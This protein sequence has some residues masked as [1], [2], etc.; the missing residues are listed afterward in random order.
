[1]PEVT[2]SPR[3]LGVDEFALHKGHN[4]GTLLL[5]VKPCGCRNVVRASELNLS[6][7]VRDSGSARLVSHL[8]VF[9]SCGRYLL[10]YRQNPG[11]RMWPCFSTP[12]VPE[13][14]G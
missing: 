4:Y 13:P 3:V 14:N 8:N 9:R 5:D 2:A 6:R 10:R 11:H 1:V 12:Q 7:V